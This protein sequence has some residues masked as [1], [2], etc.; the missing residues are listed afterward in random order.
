MSGYYARA[1]E[2]AERL[3]SH[4]KEAMLANLVL[5]Y[6]GRQNDADLRA[7]RTAM[8]QVISELTGGLN[9][10]R[11][12][13]DAAVARQSRA[14]LETACVTIL[15]LNGNLLV[16]T[17]NSPAQ[18]SLLAVFH[19]PEVRLLVPNDL[20][21]R[22]IG[23]LIAKEQSENILGIETALVVKSPGWMRLLK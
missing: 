6:Y 17:G 11:L 21:R 2:A 20:L 23:H 22:A 7:I 14:P 19:P 8:L 13:N 9:D 16:M 3:D 10:V 1:A 18:T 4:K 15:V 5:S 12:L